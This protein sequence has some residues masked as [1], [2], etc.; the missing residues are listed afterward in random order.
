[1]ELI[2]VEEVSFSYTPGRPVLDRVTLY[3]DR[4][5]TAIIG[6]NGAGKTTLVKLMKGLLKPFEG[7]I[8]VGDLSVKKVTAATLAKRIGLIFQNPNDQIFK[9]NL[10]DE[11][12]FGLLNLGVGVEEVRD[13]AIRALEMV[14][15]EA[16]RDL[17]PHDLSLSEKKLVSIASIVAMD[18]EIIIFDEP[19]IAQDHAGKERI[20]EIIRHLARQG[21]LVMTIIHD[22]DFVAESFER[23]VVLNRGRVLLDGPTRE[24]F[25]KNEVLKEAY[26]EPPSA[27]K[28][29]RQLGFSS[30]FLTTD[31]LVAAMERRIRG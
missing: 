24:V 23:I 4:R 7:E 12:S 20:K 27:A 30:T 14:G 6:Q 10:L 8:L 9:G 17:N 15:L 18:P 31:E 13:R 1:M 3:F 25:S 29:G 2:R 26:L 22:M 5:P 21:K 11:V 16:K 19:T 28:L